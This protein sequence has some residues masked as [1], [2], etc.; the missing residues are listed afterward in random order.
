MRRRLRDLFRARHPTRVVV[1]GF[2]AAIIVGTLLLWLPAASAGPGSAPIG[3]A[4]FTAT[5]SVTL[6]GLALAD[7]AEHWSGFGHLVILLLVQVGGFGLMTGASL[8]FLLAAR[9]LGLRGRLAAQAETHAIDL[10]DVRRVVLGVGALTLAFEAATALAIG[11]RLGIGGDVSP[12]RAAW[13]GIFHAVTAFNDAGITIFSGGL[14]PYVTDG[15]IVAAISIA[16]VAGGLGFPVWLD[17]AR[18]D[19]RPNRWTLH[20]KLTLATTGILLLVGVV[21]ITA[22]EWTN[23]GTLGTLDPE[24]RITAG[25]FAGVMP[26][27][28]GFNAVDYGA[29]RP[30]TLLVTDVLM[31]I[32]GGSGA[33]AGGIKVATL[34]VLMLVV[35][36]EV[37]GQPDV[38]AFRRRIPVS[39]RR[40]ALSIAVVSAATVLAGT[41]A[42]MLLS[43]L[44]LSD[45]LFEV[46]SAFSTAGLSTGVTPDLSTPAHILLGVLMFIGRVGPLTLGVALVLRESEP[47]FRHPEERPIIG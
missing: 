10:G 30:E 3:T 6:T 46:V 34:A 7:P 35:W 25:A 42:L 11:L 19:R 32:G 13:L 5:S 40:Q 38:V 26:R 45:A 28:A 21:A 16:V 20:T 15:W 9:R 4:L 41:L 14:V 37:R 12:A 31:F 44:G 17:M 47:R 1:A 2:L 18:R 36:S 8:L 23:H 39:A 33:T 29:M 27:T 43:D 22:L 24:G